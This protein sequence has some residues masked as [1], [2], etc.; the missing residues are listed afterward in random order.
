MLS[1]IVLT[2]NEEDRIKA[3]LESVKWADELIVIDEKSTDQTLEISKKYTPN[4]FS[5]N[6]TDFSARRN[7]GMEKS[8]GDWVV[9]IDADERVL[10]PLKEE[11]IKITGDDKAK[12]AYALGRVN[13]IFGQEVSYG[14][15]KNDWMI[16]MFKRSD[17]K[18]WVGE[19]HEHGE[20]SGEL[21]YAK[22]KLL[23]LT[24]RNLDQFMTKALNWSKID[25]KLRLDS[26]HP[27]MTK[28][29]FIRILL[30]ET[31]Q[32]GIRRRGFFG[33]TVGFID[34]MLQVVFFFLTYVRLWEMQQPKS[35]DLAYD[36]LDKK[37]IENGF[38]Y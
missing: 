4:V 34:S 8:K 35:L 37:L 25:A 31:Y 3:C 32:Q 2:H 1:V 5:L 23:H 30:T 21:G 15:Y 6:T 12:S 14:P 7:L 38:N 19:V 11:I 28:W 27:V 22:N 29:R 13:V 26:G 33:G 24:H 9:Y 18:T 36:E 17:F 16:R 10:Q 20:F